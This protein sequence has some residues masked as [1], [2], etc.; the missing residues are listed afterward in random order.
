MIT[1]KCL[2][3]NKE[4]NTYP[5]YIKKGWGKYCS[6]KCYGV[7][8]K[9]RHHSPKTEFK[10]GLT[11]WCSGKKCPQLSGKN[12]WN[13]QG[14]ITPLII[15]IRRCWEYK[16]WARKVKERDNFICLIC[17]DRSGRGR[18]VYLHSDHFP[19]TFNE[20]IKENNIKNFIQALNCKELWN[21]D[22]GRTLCKKCHRKTTSQYQKE[23]WKNQF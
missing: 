18:R 10:K 22:K 2:V 12:H 7:G 6:S 17:G 3:C 15:R 23:H 8:I 16:S 21:I 20:I 11:P 14:G 4:F 13:W 1:K 19:K 9:G 5:Y